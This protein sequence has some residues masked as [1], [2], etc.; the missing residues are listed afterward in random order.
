MKK[1]ITIALLFITIN[2]FSQ[3]SK[4]DS[5]AQAE[6]YKVIDSVSKTSSIF[7]LVQWSEANVRGTKSQ[8]DFFQ[9]VYMGFLNQKYNEFIQRKQKP[10]TNK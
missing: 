5:L 9:A 10:K 7:D 3:T 4:A 8:L 1:A 6:Y 2:S